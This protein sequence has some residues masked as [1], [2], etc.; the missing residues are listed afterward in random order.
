MTGDSAGPGKKVIRIIIAGAVVIIVLVSI[1]FVSGVPPMYGNTGYKSPHTI[2]SE[3]PSLTTVACS[4][5]SIVV[6]YRGGPNTAMLTNISVSVD[7]MPRRSLDPTIGSEMIMPASP[8]G[9]AGHR[10]IVLSE[11][12]DGEMAIDLDTMLKCPQS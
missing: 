7:G 3:N 1:I 8:G 4:G 9:T 6:H 2:T 5:N 10:V 11:F 12:S